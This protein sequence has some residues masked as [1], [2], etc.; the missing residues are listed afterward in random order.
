M[1]HLAARETP[2]IFA[3]RARGVNRPPAI[4]AATT[5]GKKVAEIFARLC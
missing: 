3:P 2:A 5:G 1:G 4:R